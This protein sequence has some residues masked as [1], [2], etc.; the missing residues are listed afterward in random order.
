M[1]DFNEFADKAKKLASEHS[2]QADSGFDKAA[3]FADE[4]TGNRFGS[5][6]QQGEQA[7]ENYLGVQDQGPAGSAAGPGPG[8][9]PVRDQGQG[10]AGYGDQGQGGGRDQGQGGA[11]TATR[12]RAGPVRRPGQA[13]TSTAT[14]ARAGPVRRPGPGR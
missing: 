11:S 4:K 10:G 2:D 5:Q 8:R 1:P 6:I 9:R 12:A 7:G 14:R 3:E 13:V